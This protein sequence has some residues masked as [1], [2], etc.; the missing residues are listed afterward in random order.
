VDAEILHALYNFLE[1]A[2][3]LDKARELLL[4]LDHQDQG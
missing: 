1:D 4:G 2:S 3:A